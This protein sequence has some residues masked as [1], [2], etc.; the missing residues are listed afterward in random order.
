M[1]L[2]PLPAVQRARLHT[3][4][5]RHVLTD[6]KAF[7]RWFEAVLKR[8]MAHHSKKTDPAVR[9]RGLLS[10]DDD[11]GSPVPRELFDLDRPYDPA[12]AKVLLKRFLAGLNARK[13]GFLTS[14]GAAAAARARKPKNR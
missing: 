12:D 14:A 5:V 3:H 9:D 13:N 2:R 11:L 7:D 4:F 8:L 10:N 6:R 1:A